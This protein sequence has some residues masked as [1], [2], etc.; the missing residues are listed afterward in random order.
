AYS[1]GFV[2][3]DDKSSRL[4]AIAT[5]SAA[6]SPL[7]VVF[8]DGFEQFWDGLYVDNG[9]V[10]RDLR[11]NCRKELAKRV[12][13]DVSSS[14]GYIRPALPSLLNGNKNFVTGDVQ[15]TYQPTGTTLAVSYREMRQPQQNGSGGD[16]RSE[17]VN[18]RVA[19]ALHFL[20]DLKLLLGV[21]V[22]RA[23]NSP[24]LLDTIDPNGVTR[25]YIGGLAVNF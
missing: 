17:R 14:A 16:Y 19:Q 13:V 11:V 3:G 8:T 23:D 20:L 4:S 5:V 1:F 21:E 12:L 7:R 9:D 18:V 25:K 15:S 24:Y 10:R 2:S 22:A 6:D